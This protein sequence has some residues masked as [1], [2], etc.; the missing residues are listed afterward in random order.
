[1]DQLAD[2]GTSRGL[3]GGLAHPLHGGA[4]VPGDL[5][6]LP[7]P[8]VEPAVGPAH[9]HPTRGEVPVAPEVLGEGQ[10]FPAASGHAD[11]RL[12]CAR[13]L[14]SAGCPEHSQ[15]PGAHREPDSQL[16]QHHQRPRE[17]T[18]TSSTVDR[19]RRAARP[20]PPAPPTP[21]GSSSPRN[22]QT[23]STDAVRCPASPGQLTGSE[24]PRL[25]RRGRGRD[26]APVRGPAVV[27]ASR[28][29][30]RRRRPPATRAVPIR[31]SRVG[32]RHAARPRPSP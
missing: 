10:G 20:D 11:H 19:R 23:R 7:V 4:V 9:L 12:R 31:R 8:A 3:Q 5:P 13:R 14:D 2:G 15:P 24:R 1:V 32:R 25:R 22:A 17:R 21:T 27:A 16:R 18:R 28:R 26:P 29:I 6:A 30:P